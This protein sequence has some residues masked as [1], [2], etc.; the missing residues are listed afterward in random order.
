MKY[1]A[2]SRSAVPYNNSNNNS[3]NTINNFHCNNNI[4]VQKY[5]LNTI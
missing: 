2:V 5:T 3:N 4:I 1:L